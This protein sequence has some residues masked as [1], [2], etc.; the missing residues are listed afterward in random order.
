MACRNLHQRVVRWP[1]A[2][3]FRNPFGEL[4]REERCDLAV[5]DLAP[6]LNRIAAPHARPPRPRFRPYTAYQ[7]VGDVGRGKTT[8]MLAIA[9]QFPSA[10]YVYL[11]EDE[12]CPSIPCGTPL[13]IDEAQRLPRKVRRTI[14]GSG[15]TLILATHRDL[16]GPLRRS[17]Y[18]VT[19][20]RIGQE[21]SAELLT[22]MLNRRI[23]A[24]R[25]DLRQ[26]AP[27]LQV[28]EAEELIRRYGTNI[29]SIESYLYE[30][31]QS[32]VNDHGKMRFIN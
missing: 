6:I 9:R 16:T 24:S 29:R 5:V 10:S 31:V 15:E 14:F 18:E 26:P 2:N 7:L 11:P 12:P 28:T 19:T 20:E 21:L 1:G 17:G 13:M 30:V 22:E 8:R 23:N 27:L 4:T 3:L 32:Q 25:R